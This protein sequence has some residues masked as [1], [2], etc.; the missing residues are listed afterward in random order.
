MRTTLCVSL[1]QSQVQV[2]KIYVGDGQPELYQK[3]FTSSTTSLFHYH[4]FA[5]FYI[6]YQKWVF[7]DKTRVLLITP[8]W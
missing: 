5:S 3:D 2:K 1:G 8:H 4:C 6:R 7:I